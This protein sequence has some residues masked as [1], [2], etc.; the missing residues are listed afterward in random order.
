M[1]TS[2]ATAAPHAVRVHLLKSEKALEVAFSDGKTFRYPAEL[3]RAES[4]SVQGQGRV[5]SGRRHIGV[6][7]AEPVGNYAVRLQF[8]DLHATGIYTWPFLHELGRNKFARM[9]RYL[10]ALRERGLSRDPP[11]RGVRR[12]PPAR[13]AQGAAAA[14]A[15]SRD[16]Q[17][18]RICV[19]A[20]GTLL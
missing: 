8:D 16:R 17:R 5:V 3:L 13:A 9:R 19:G 18:G 2:S 6:M 15:C 11:K 12:T 10:R 7:S 4:P 20:L 14:E 1:V